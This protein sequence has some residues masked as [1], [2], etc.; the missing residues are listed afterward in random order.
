MPEKKRKKSKKKWLFIG[1]GAIL[2]AVFI[3]INMMGE[4]GQGTNV[5]AETVAR[6]DLTEIVSASG[7]IQPQTKVDITS[8]VNGE[9][10]ALFVDEGNRV[11]VGAPL[12]V[13]DTVQLRSDVDQM[14]YSLNEVNAR[15]DGAKSSLDQSAEEY[16]RQ[17][18]LRE[19]EGTSETALDN[20]KYAF[21]NAQ[22][23]YEA[24]K[25]STSRTR[26]QLEK[27]LDNLSK[28][29]I[30]A[31]MAGVITFLDCEVGE[32]A[33][34]QTMYS[35][36]RV[37]MTISNLDGF[38]VEVEVDET[39]I[40]KVDIQQYTSIEVD[41]F[42]DTTFDGH[43]VEIGNTAIS[44]GYGTENQSTNFRVKV[45][46]DD[47]A[48]RL[49]PGMSATVDI[50]T[51]RGD[52]VLAIPYSAVVMRSFD[53]DSLARA[54]EAES[55]ESSGVVQAVHAAETTVEE[56]GND[57]AS[58]DVEREEL[59]GVFVI[60]DNVARFVEIETGI[61]D[62]RRIEVVSG[63]EENDSVISGPYR[64]LREVKDGDDVAIT[65]MGEESEGNR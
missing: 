43:V 30:V 24:L 29:K 15:L 56:D 41:A 8:E 50:T 18:K 7:R 65:R 61:A 47:P 31:P 42:P 63:L 34:A 5:Q 37:L 10:M 54:R 38:E 13:L 11:E 2:L 58:A 62:K 59:K 25:A 45:V 46:F 20:A 26:S 28:A 4:G 52:G 36:G 3:G 33:A 35:Q 22:S 6:R 19:T 17:K 60:R 39:E 51:A 16:E 40:N 21:L 14:R 9:I 23:S 53:L 57:T 27:A 12:L 32:I 48:V 49:R 64:V 44:S 55:A 1:G